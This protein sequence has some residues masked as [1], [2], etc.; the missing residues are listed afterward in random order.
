MKKLLLLGLA[1]VLL[2][3]GPFHC[4]SEETSW[5]SHSFVTRDLSRAPAEVRLPRELWEK[6]ED[7]GRGG[8]AAGKGG[9]G[10]GHEGGAAPAEGGH[11]G[12]SEHKSNVATVF[13]SLKVYLIEK[14]PGILRDGNTKIEF[15]PGGGE[16]DFRDFVE[17]HNG[18]F[19]F[20]AEFMPDLKD[21]VQSVYFMS[22]GVERKIGS[23]TYGA[24]CD[25]Y[26]NISNAFDKAL[27][28]T[29]FLVNTT[30]GRHIAALAG[31]YFFA[32]SHEGKLY[33]A[34]LTIKDST[35]KSWQCK[36]DPAQKAASHED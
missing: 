16:I 25:T 14:N 6:I 2:A 30:E 35:R 32:A 26:F 13:A 33:L 28:G 27:K 20:T 3:F 12:G 15:G 31:N 21:A 23:E 8:E 36:R 1:P 17:A 29:G 11:G 22:N 34:S 19:Y 24:G 4:T 9:G 5:R 18:S 10:G 7:L